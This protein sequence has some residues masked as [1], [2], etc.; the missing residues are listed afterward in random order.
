VGIHRVSIYDSGHLSVRIFRV[1]FCLVSFCPVT[2]KIL[3]ANTHCKYFLKIAE[4][5]RFS[6]RGTACTRA[7]YNPSYRLNTAVTSQRY[8]TCSARGGHFS[9]GL[10]GYNIGNVQQFLKNTCSAY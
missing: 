5:T 1:G 8:V 9:K 2:V 7:L 10:A 4:I 6:V 3:A